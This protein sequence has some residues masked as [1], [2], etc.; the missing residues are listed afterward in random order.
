MK[1]LFIPFVTMVLF[2]FASCKSS[3][4]TEIVTD[5][6]GEWNIVEVNGSALNNIEPCPYIGFDTE[7][8]RIYG[9][10]GCNR[11]MSSLTLDKKAGK[12]EFGQ[13]AS[14]M[15]AG[16]NMDIER[17]VLNALAQVK[18]YKQMGKNEIA[19]C[20][21]SKRPVIIL[22]KRFYAIST[23]DLNGEW[24]IV[25]VHNENIP[26]TIETIPYIVLNIEEKTF[27]GNAGCNT[28][29]GKMQY[30]NNPE[31]QNI[32]FEDIISTR[33]MCPSMDIE[34]KIITTLKTVKTCGKLENGN[35]VFY[36]N[37]NQVMELKK[38]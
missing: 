6:H 10:S 16:P 27:T 18:N 32:S 20:N 25:K 13:M 3:K 29:N 11:I 23:A 1:K 14:T 31:G 28:I 17:N 37:G 4:N 21:D 30:Q 9:N 36:D 19:L 8:G 5:L 15:M 33:M 7:N 22:K 12:I 35:L 38:K 24:E 26:S 34:N 2:V